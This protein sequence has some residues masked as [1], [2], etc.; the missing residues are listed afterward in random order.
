MN[1]PAWQDAAVAVLAALALVWLV[2]R[3]L[4]RRHRPTPLCDEC[5]GCD[6]GLLAAPAPPREA[7]TRIRSPELTRRGR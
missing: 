7:Q 3:R 2:R 5:P 1:A 4:R 6:P